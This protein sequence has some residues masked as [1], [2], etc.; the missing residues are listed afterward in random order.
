VV[1]ETESRGKSWERWKM[2]RGVQMM[3]I[4]D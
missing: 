2:E 4:D 1:K 3:C